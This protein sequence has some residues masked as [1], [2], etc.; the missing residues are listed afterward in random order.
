MIHTLK[1]YLV[2]LLC[3]TILSVAVVK[4]YQ[5]P[6][7]RKRLI[8][9]STLKCYLQTE[10]LTIMIYFF[11]VYLI[12]EFEIYFIRFTRLN[13]IHMLWFN[14]WDHF[15]HW[16]LLPRCP[17]RTLH[18]HHLCTGLSTVNTLN[19]T[20]TYIRS[21]QLPNHTLF[22]FVFLA[23]DFCQF[24]MVIWFF[25]PRHNGQWPLTLKDFLSQILSITFIFLS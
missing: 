17:H 6:V 2:D 21:Y 22:F 10:T 1:E 12:W 19:S 11:I 7:I 23:F 24:C 9:Y 18:S 25:H 14:T 15:Y 16:E 13:S 20:C 5:V 8:F 3:S 4:E